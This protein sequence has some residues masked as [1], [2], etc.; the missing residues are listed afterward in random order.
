MSDNESEPD[1]EDFEDYESEPDSENFDDGVKKNELIV[2]KLNLVL[3]FNAGLTD[4]DLYYIELSKINGQ[5]EKIEYFNDSDLFINKENELEELLEQYVSKIKNPGDLNES[6]ITKIKKRL[7]DLQELYNKNEDSDTFEPILSSSFESSWSNLNELEKTQIK[8]IAEK[9]KLV[10]PE[11]KNFKTLE[12]YNIA[13]SDFYYL[14]LQYLPG[15]WEHFEI[16]EQREIELLAKKMK[17]KKPNRKM[18]GTEPEFNKA[19]A[20][21]LKKVAQYLPGYV[22]KMNITSIGGAYNLIVSDKPDISEQIKIIQELPIRPSESDEIVAKNNIILK[23]LLTKLDREH[24]INCASVK[25]IPVEDPQRTGKTLKIQEEFSP[26]KIRN[27]KY[28]VIKKKVQVKINQEILKTQ[29]KVLNKSITITNENP[30]VISDTERKGY[31]EKLLGSLLNGVSPDLIINAPGKIDKLENYIYTLSMRLSDSFKIYSDKISD[32]LFIFENYPDLKIKLLTD[33]NT[34]VFRLVL[35]EKEIKYSANKVVFKPGI[36]DRRQKLRNL[37]NLFKIDTIKSDIFAKE[38]CKSIELLLYDIS[39][40][41]QEYGINYNKFLNL[42][43]IINLNKITNEQILSLMNGVDSAPLAP[44][45]YSKFSLIE[46]DAF[47]DQE[48]MLRKKLKKKLNTIEA[49]N[50]RGNFIINWVPN[51][52][53]VPK[54]EI[55]I[56]NRLKTKVLKTIHP[57]DL[58]NIVIMNSKLSEL[59]GFKQSLMKKYK[60]YKD[61]RVYSIKQEIEDSKAKK[62]KLNKLRVERMAREVPNIEVTQKNE[63]VSVVYPLVNARLI[64]QVILSYKRKLMV[65][66]L[67]QLQKNRIIEI[68]ELLDFNDLNFMENIIKTPEVYNR[69]RDRLISELNQSD[70]QMTNEKYLIESTQVIGNG[71]SF[72]EIVKGW[73]KEYIP[74]RKII[75]FYG[76][77]IFLKLFKTTSP[78]N[79][80]DPKFRNRYDLFV[81][82]VTPK[83]D[84]PLPSNKVMYDPYIGTFGDSVPNGY[85]FDVY[86]LDRDPASMMPILLYTHT[87]VKDPDGT[88]KFQQVTVEKYGNYKFIKVPYLTNKAGVIVHHWIELP[89]G[90]RTVTSD[91]DSCTRFDKDSCNTGTGI[92][93]SKC[94]YSERL[95]KCKAKYNI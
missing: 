27:K 26:S 65:D 22:Y 23:N 94:E 93:N 89:P 6:E 58:N 73:P 90:T 57:S 84:A 14:M 2:Q 8:K 88:V 18:Y 54:S 91:Y 66:K 53:I 74:Q 20:A 46:L 75:D 21:F 67:P 15:Y 81:S 41:K 61:P 13:E 72:D 1:S 62:L 24:L 44:V 70:Y 36:N 71:K 16:K 50:N 4:T 82:S 49:D 9:L 83:R 95:K 47:L 92:A 85:L 19:N 25:K 56:W 63:I 39:N 76:Q 69:I 11:K 12:E 78:L 28:Y 52:A 77:D 7:S 59:S 32:I 48:K 38:R 45:D 3:K 60:I 51:A 40:T 35:F 87:E 86:N 55:E 30:R 80:Y 33:E 17:L 64:Y 34:S 43:S 42:R 5:L 31:R 10:F 37:K 68:L 79:F 29:I